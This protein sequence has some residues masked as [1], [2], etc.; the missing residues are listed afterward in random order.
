MHV[1][2]V[3]DPGTAKSSLISS[4]SKLAPK[5]RLTGGK[6]ASGAGL[7]ATVVKDEFL[8]GWALEAGAIVLANG[9]HLFIDEL[10]KMT[11]ED[12]NAL[13][14]A[15]EQQR[16]SI[17]KANI[18]AT[19]KAE[20]S[21]LAAANPKLSRFDPY[22]PIAAQID[23]PA[24]LINRFDL[25][26]PIRDIQ[27]REIDEKIAS[28]VLN[29]HQEVQKIEPK[30]PPQIYK[31]Y[32]SYAKKI[33][34][35]LGEKAIEEIKRF[36]VELRN[37]DTGDGEELKPIPI[38]ARQLEALIRLSEGSARLRLSKKVTKK[39][40]KIAID[41]LR[42]CLMQVGFDYETGQIDIDKI[43]TGM[44]TS[45]RSKIVTVR[46]IINDLEN[47]VGKNIPLEEVIALSEVK[48]ISETQVEESIEKLKK[49]GFL[50]EP[51][52]GVI[53]KL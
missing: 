13:H 33:K 11:V 3:G 37:K 22:T 50:F 52:R 23:L 30:I 51:R 24:S 53:S 26:F 28:H 40:A 31:K 10:D 1:L 21:V 27:N 45:T 49:E 48:N 41:L 44:T 5:S 43:Y 15:L 34:P 2:L 42:Y 29:I 12:R 35:V 18:Q 38:S 19:L 14:E 16:I 17:S 9:G 47:K 4:L 8:K 32:V 39:D 20:T 36:Y 25:I 6:S 46:E 7:T